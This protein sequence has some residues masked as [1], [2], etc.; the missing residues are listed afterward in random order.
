MRLSMANLS[1]DALRLALQ[2]AVGSEALMARGQKPPSDDPK[3]LLR[4]LLNALASADTPTE[5]AETDVRQVKRAI[6]DLESAQVHAVQAQTQGLQEMFRLVLPFGDADPVELAFERRPASGDQAQTLTV[7]VHS[8][9][10][11]FG[12]LW[13]KTE[14]HGQSEV[15]LV[16]WAL[17]AEVTEKA[18]L[19][20]DA[21]STEL[22]GAGLVMRSF[23]AIHGA[24]PAQAAAPAPSGS[25]L[26]LD[27]Q[28]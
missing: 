15:T 18:R 6:D 20:A 9:S 3:Q 27:M 8:N 12:E 2:A 21:L 11:D 25:G 24:R 14:L 4:K 1:P 10:R 28:A 13:L 19:R 23:Q 17:Q 5:E 7:N 22:L 26:I 16:M